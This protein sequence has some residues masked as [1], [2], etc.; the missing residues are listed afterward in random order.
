V[1]EGPG[2]QFWAI[3]TPDSKAVVYNSFMASELDLWIRPI[4]LSQPPRR[5]TFVSRQLHVP[6]DITRDGRTVFLGAT[7]GLNE[8]IDIHVLG[9]EGDGATQPLLELGAHAVQAKLS[10]DGRLLAYASDRSGR[11]EVYVQSF[12]E[13]GG[14]VR[15][16]PR[17]G[18]EPLWSPSGDLIYY[19]SM[20]GKQIFAVEVEDRDP[21]RLGTETLIAEGDFDPGIRWGR[22]W[23]I[24]PDGDRF[25]VLQVES[26]ES[27]GGIQ[28][29]K[30]WFS[31]L[32]ELVPAVP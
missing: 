27:P 9:L 17:G 5:L 16:S 19:R 1:T 12:P 22:K 18:Q 2:N 23:D 31:E 30:N 20:N 25:L 21:L 32:E 3:W 26:Y 13:A 24:H 7:S 4:D 10:P 29:V 11:F 28:V 15:V 8:I 14:T 6:M